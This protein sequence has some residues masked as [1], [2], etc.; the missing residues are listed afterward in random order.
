MPIKRRLQR[1]RPESASELLD[2]VENLAGEARLPSN[3]PVTVAMGLTSQEAK[4][5]GIEAR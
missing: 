1:T 3:F 4:R 5:M 2:V